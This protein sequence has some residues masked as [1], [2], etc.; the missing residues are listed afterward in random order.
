M[1]AAARIPLPQQ[2]ITT[3][4]NGTILH[5]RMPG[6]L[7]VVSTPIGNLDDI[8]LR[9]LNTL[10]SVALIASEDTRR[11]GT[12]LRHFGITTPTTSL[13]EH[14]ERQKLHHVLKRLREGADVALVSDAG[15]PLISDPGQ[16]LI[17]AAIDEGIT[18]VPVPGPSAVL[19]AL[20]ASGFPANT[21]VFA[22]F[23]PYRSK[24]RKNWLASLATE[25]RTVVFFESP[26]RI[27]G[28]LNDMRTIL[29][30]RPISIARELTK[31]HEKTVHIR[32]NDLVNG[33]VPARGEFTIVVAP[34][35]PGP[36]TVA[37][38]TDEEVRHIFDQI[39]NNGRLSRRQAVA[40]TAHK[41][42]LSTNQVYGILER[43]K[44]SSAP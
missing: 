35:T 13:H 39:T 12:L 19:S 31:L 29:G 43:S 26:H 42:G 37:A 15:T 36:E 14:N 16:R 18:V 8:T 6:R 32:A 28:T 11:T 10:K 30:D 21:F 41:F 33:G 3:N 22:G 23:A 20:V 9:A 17:A 27:A 2:Q 7:H 44:A 4:H 34:A 38:P 1:K 5:S 25:S 40:E 24:D